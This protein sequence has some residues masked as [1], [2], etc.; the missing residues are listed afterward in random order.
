[1]QKGQDHSMAVKRPPQPLFSLVDL[2]A[3]DA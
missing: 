1:M 2:L 3:G